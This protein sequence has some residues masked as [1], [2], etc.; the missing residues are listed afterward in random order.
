MGTKIGQ[1]RYCIKGYFGCRHL[2]PDWVEVAAFS[3]G[4]VF[5]LDFY[6]SGKLE[7]YLKRVMYF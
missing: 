3:S 7:R 5:Q 4:S 2:S 6:R 1:M